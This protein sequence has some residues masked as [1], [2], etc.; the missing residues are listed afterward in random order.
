MIIGLVAYLLLSSQFSTAI[1]PILI[2]LNLQGAYLGAA[3]R[4]YS[5]RYGLADSP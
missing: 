3:C 1:R 4:A 2:Y 5:P